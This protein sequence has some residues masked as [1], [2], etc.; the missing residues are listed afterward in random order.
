MYPYNTESAIEIVTERNK[1]D[2]YI[3]FI[4]AN[5]ISQAW[6]VMPNLEFLKECPTLKYLNV[7]P[8][9]NAPETFSFSPLYDMKE[10]KY[11]VCNNVY[12]D[13]EEF[14][15]ELDCK[16][17]KGL[18]FLSVSF[19]KGIVNLSKIKNL[20]TLRIRDYKCKEKDLR[21][22]FESKVLD[23]IELT[24]CG[25]QSLNGIE[26]SEMMQCIY[27]NYNRTLKDISRLEKVK[28]TLKTL[29][30]ESVLK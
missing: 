3:D 10:I 13:K 23:T 2:E 16:K 24:E 22:L 5:N 4:N 28:N 14:W 12:G 15:V 1:L 21:N 26:Q 11:L 7:S 27:L 29:H 30:I 17:I 19:N 9:Y 6:I 25:I 8:S 18:E 20:K